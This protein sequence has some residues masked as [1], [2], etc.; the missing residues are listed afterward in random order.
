MED[1]LDDEG[2]TNQDTEA[3][4]ANPH[5]PATADTCQWVKPM[6]IHL[7]FYSGGKTET[8]RY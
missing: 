4:E 7:H 3:A 2:D 8:K 5:E 6:I 1:R